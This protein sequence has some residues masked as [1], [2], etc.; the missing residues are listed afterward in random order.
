MTLIDTDVTATSDA[1]VAEI[2]AA[3]AAAHRD[4]A[5]TPSARR[6][7]VLDRIADAL[8]ADADDLVAIAGA[9][10]NLPEG[11]LRGE[12]RRTAFQLRLFGEQLRD[13]GYLDARIDPADPDWPMGAPRPDLRRSLRPIGPVA[14]FAASNFPFAFSVVGGDTASALAAGNAVVVKAHAG[15]P[16]LSVRTAD[17]VRAT[18]SDVGVAPELLGLVVGREA[19]VTL[20]QDPRIRAAGFTGSIP[21]GRALLALANERPEPIPFYGEL[22]STNPVFVTTAAAALRGEEIANG[23][24]GSVTLGS[25]QFCT[26]PGMLFVP[27][28][29]G[30]RER[31]GA[32]TL[33]AVG[34]MLNEAIEAGFT[35]ALDAQRALPAVEPLSEGP[36]GDG[37]APTPVLLATTVEALLADP[38]AIEAECFGP[39]AIVVEYGDEDELVRAAATFEGQ[40]TAT[41][42]AEESDHVE[43]LVRELVD[44]A[45]RV[46][47]NEWPTGVSV[48]HAQQH[49]GPYPATTV[50]GS[51]SVGTAAITRFLRPVAFQNFPQRLLPPELQ[52]ANPTRAPRLVDGVRIDGGPA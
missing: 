17:V 13:G 32:A 15:H 18:L 7:D 6:A 19:G 43:D 41:L 29:S 47:W 48:T 42:Q 44:R 26:K 35:R 46:L 11:R 28:G 49:G 37:D 14:V 39:S 27:V 45:G 33:P 3:A 38:A 8:E 23:F 20:I 21:G 36:A 9:E 10:T 5:A 12:V 40:L 2:V 52:D 25:G 34:P 51:T 50:P 22:G 16:R 31:L 24:L 4:W 1:Q 30:L